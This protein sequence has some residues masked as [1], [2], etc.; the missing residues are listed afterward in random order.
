MI[1]RPFTSH[2]RVLGST[3]PKKVFLFSFCHNHKVNIQMKLSNKYFLCFLCFFIIWW[4]SYINFRQSNG[5][6]V[7]ITHKYDNSLA[8][9]FLKPKKPKKSR[10]GEGEGEEEGEEE[11]GEGGE[12]EEG[13]ERQWDEKV[14]FEMRE[15]FKKSGKMSKTK[16]GKGKTSVRR[17]WK[18]VN[19]KKNTI[20]RRSLKKYFRASQNGRQW[21]KRK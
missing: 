4:V 16:K 21:L 8:E 18:A 12:E 7:F 2:Y 20:Q 11:E 9:L 19:L 17:T 5:G 1:C 6:T 15:V 3:F 10:E 14:S 13:W